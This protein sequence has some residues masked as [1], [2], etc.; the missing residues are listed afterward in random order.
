[1]NQRKV[2]LYTEKEK[3]DK[4][5]QKQNLLDDPIF[6]YI[7]VFTLFLLHELDVMQVL[8]QNRIHLI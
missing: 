7:Y 2:T 5:K 6:I 4:T 1:M 8:F 3:K